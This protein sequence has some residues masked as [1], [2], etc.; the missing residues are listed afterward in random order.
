MRFSFDDKELVSWDL[1]NY[2]FKFTITPIKTTFYSRLS[3]II[4]MN[5]DVFEKWFIDL[6]FNTILIITTI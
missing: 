4:T 5:P 3:I 1:Q 6:I 2:S